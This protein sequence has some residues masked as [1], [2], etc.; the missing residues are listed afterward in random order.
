MSVRQRWI[1]I[2]IVA[3]AF[4]LRIAALDLRPA[5]FDEGVNG[6]FLDDMRTRGCY[7]YNP[8]NFHGP[9]H[10]YT[11]FAAQQLFGRS[12][13]V[14]R[15]PTAL[16]G[17]AAIALMLAFRRFLPW[18]AVWIGALAAAISP[19]MVFYSR[20]AIHEM[21]LPF[22][23]LLAVYGGFGIARREGRVGDLWAFGIGL[24]GMVLTKET[25]LVHWIAAV[26]ALVA[27]RCLDWFAPLNPPAQRPRPADLFSGRSSDPAAEA[28]AKAAHF[29]SRQIATV[30][31]SCI[32]AV[33]LFQSGFGMYPAGI[34]GLFETFRLMYDKG[35]TAEAGHNKEFFY[36]LKLMTWYEWPALIGLAAAPVLSLRRSPLP[37][38]ALLL[39]GALLVGAGYFSVSVGI[40]DEIAKDFLKPELTLTGRPLA[41]IPSLGL[42]LLACSL[43]FF[44]AAPSQNRETR[45]LCLYALASF[46]AYSLIPY[47]TPWCIINLLWPFLF[48]LGQL[49]ENL[50]QATDRRLVYAVGLLLAWTPLRDCW[51]L[52]FRHP[53]LD[54]DHY[55]YVHTHPEINRLLS[56]VRTLARE[57]PLQ[58]QMHGLILTESFPLT[59]ELNEFPNITWLDENATVENYDADFILVPAQRELEF[60][61]RAFGIYY[62]ESCRLR[63]G[64]DRGWLYLSADRFASLFPGRTPE[65]HPRVPQRN[66]ALPEPLR[67]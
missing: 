27:A 21:W 54:G 42:W 23:T 17:T 57:D 13:W 63:Y 7:E 47:K 41:I 37:A 52:N 51:Q 29:T 50:M 24:S 43:G 36:W 60:E 11:L 48:A 22:F 30:A 16:I 5:H 33:L 66:P 38:A 58:R 8:A 56:A 12:L 44:A 64:T 9:L 45:W 39:G 28:I 19:A 3:L 40:H 4:A 15:M 18:R 25:Y 61:D 67:K 32:A 49:A 1:S 35:T 6:S 59:W 31:F 62:K 14:L 34:K 46:T 26:L 55:A 65:I 2:L 20:Y 53:T 10:F